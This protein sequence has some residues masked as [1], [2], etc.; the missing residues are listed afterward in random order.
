M[1]PF[2]EAN[3]LLPLRLAFNNWIQYVGATAKSMFRPL[4]WV[5]IWAE[6]DGFVG[7]RDV[8]TR[9]GRLF[10]LLSKG[11]CQVFPRLEDPM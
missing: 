11:F 6:K 9:T 2:T 4:G 1:C 3:V 7:K 8:F 5:Y 10:I